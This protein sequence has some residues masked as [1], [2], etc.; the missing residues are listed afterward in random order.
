MTKL[1]KRCKHN[2]NGM[3]STCHTTQVAQTL[4]CYT[5][6]TMR[7]K[8]HKKVHNIYG[9]SGHKRWQ[10]SM[11]MMTMLDASTIDGDLRPFI[12]IQ[13]DQAGQPAHRLSPGVSARS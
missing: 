3:L 5:V 11:V 8:Q 1:K 10:T 2:A 12:S 7:D 13:S 4:A 6:V 9:D